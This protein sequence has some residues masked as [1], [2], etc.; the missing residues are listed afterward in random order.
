MKSSIAA[1]AIWWSLLVS[2][3]TLRDSALRP[4]WKL[5]RI[6]HV[7]QAGSSGTTPAQSTRVI[8]VSSVASIFVGI[9]RGI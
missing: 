3:G 6:L 7:A 1:T 5:L 4:D 2:D 9:R 8:S